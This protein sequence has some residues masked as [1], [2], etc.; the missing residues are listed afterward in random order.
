MLRALDRK[1]LRDLWH[2]KGQALAIAGV[3]AAG[4]GV[5]VMSMGTQRSLE[6]TRDAYYERYRFADVFAS[7]KRAPEHL[8]TAIARLPGVAGVETRVVEDVTLDVVGMA[9]PAVGRLV[10]VPEGELGRLNLVHLREGRNVRLGA[11]DEVVI[12]ETF[13]EAH[14]LGPGAE[15]TAVING[16][17]RD[18]SVVGIG[19]SPEYVY[20]IPAG[21]LMP[22][23]KRFGVLWM[24]RQALEAAFDL[25]GAFNALSLALERGADEDEVIARLDG[26]L[27]PYG[28][29]GAYGRDIQ[30]SNWY[31]SGEM[32]QLTTMTAVIPPIFV[33]VAAFLLNI[34]LTRLIA[35]EREQIGLL[36]AF[37]YSHRSVGLHYL[38][39]SLAIVAIGILMGF[40]IG[41]WLGRSLTEMYTVFFRFPFLFYRASP[42]VFAFGALVGLVVGG[43][44]TIIG[45]RRAASLPP[46]EAMVPAPPT[47]Y[48]KT[49]IERLLLRIHMGEPTN[50][51]LRHVVRW[52]MRSSLTVL[53]VAMGMG[54]LVGTLFFLD[55][56]DHLVETFFFRAQRADVIVTFSEARGGRVADELA[57]MPGVL[58][59]EPFRTV[60][61]RLRAGHREKRE[62]LMGIGEGSDLYRLLDTEERPVAVPPWGLSLSDRLARDLGVGPGD[63]V[64]VH[65]MEGRRPV[66]RLPVATVTEAYIGTP[67]FLE[68][69]VLNRV[70]K[71]GDVSSG[72]HLMVAGHRLADLNRKLKDTPGVA[73]VTLRSAAID[74]FRKTMAETVL[75]IVGFYIAFAGVVAFGVVYNAARV[76]LSERGRELA[77]LRVLGFTKGEVSYILLGEL[78]L[79]VLLALAPGAAIGW[80]LARFWVWSLDT[81]LYRIPLVV[82]P[83]TYG[84]GALV[85]TAAAMV[86]GWAIKRR[87][88]RLDL[89]AV[90]KT[91][92]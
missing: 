57:H 73:A 3:V 40:A 1:L 30:L 47:R 87:L 52:P 8:A 55:A 26:L 82:E 59:V 54:L 80:S 91:R 88:D 61:A 46:A 37:G 21:A 85:V 20:S 29:P 72:A 38:K 6:E 62:G 19:L 14:G 63:E 71:E 45:V 31:L 89:V 74:S 81:E 15:L 58:R 77:S 22:D 41:D 33:G 68:R 36:K 42:D 50:M 60:S 25:E 79:L 4:V 5:F 43:L 16:R 78:G 32:D 69:G 92:E 23:N 84:A 9:E 64:E 56:V 13:A 53:G 24:G 7:A 67:A 39:L 76:S 2:I 66:L 28:G 17:K 27:D 51:I 44:G 83:T 65:V 70:M 49:G 10:S 11:P 12:A 35:T 86:S 18:L 90:L 75:T 48:A 34:V